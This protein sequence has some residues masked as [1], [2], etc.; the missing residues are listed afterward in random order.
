[1]PEDLLP[2]LVLDASGRVRG[3][4]E[5][6][7]NHRLN[8]VRLQEAPKDYAPLTV[9]VWQK[10]GSKSGWADNGEELAEGVLNTIMTKPSEGS[11]GR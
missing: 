8:V 2:L 11:L 6:M 10:S 1:M 7:E 9:H 5:H 4:Y 3:T